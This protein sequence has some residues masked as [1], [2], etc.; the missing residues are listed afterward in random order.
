MVLVANP[1]AKVG[2]SSTQ[3][4]S[5]AVTFANDLLIRSLGIR[6]HDSPYEI[7]CLASLS[8]AL[9]QSVSMI[10]SDEL[11]ESVSY[12]HLTLPTTR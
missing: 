1:S 9:S 6:S 2:N 4:I 12:T 5:L 7:S 11:P 8:P 10:N 3:E